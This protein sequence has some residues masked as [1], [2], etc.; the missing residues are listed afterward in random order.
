MTSSR[1][2]MRATFFARHPIRL[3]LSAALL[4]AAASPLYADSVQRVDTL[5]VTAAGFE[6]KLTD[7]PASISVITREDL[8]K[9]PYMTLLDAV[10]DLEGVDVGETRDKTG[11]GSI[12]M[13]GMGAD[14]TLILINGRRQNNNGDIYPNS[15][16]GNQFNHI[17]PLDAIERIEVI[18]GPAATLYGADAMGGVINIITRRDME[19]WSGSLTFGR[20]YQSNKDLGDDVTTDVYLTG[21]LIPGI[22]GMALRGSLYDRMASNPQY[23]PVTDPAGEKHQRTLGFGGGG[24]TV[25]NTNLAG[26]FSLYWTPDERQHITFDYDTSEQTYNNDSSQL[27]TLDSI[28]TVWRAQTINGVSGQVAPRVGYNDDQRFTREQWA[29]THEGRWDFAKT[30]VSLSHISSQNHGRTLPFTIDERQHLQ[31]IYSGTGVYAGL[32]QAERK[33]LAEATFLPRP[34]RTM[35]SREYTLDAKLEKLMGNHQVVAGGQLIR[36]ELEDG[37]FG[38][39]GGGYKSG[40]VQEHHMWALF[41]EDNWMLTPDL[42]LTGGLRYDN[43]D[44]FGGQTSP[45]LYAVYNLSDA[46]TVKGGVSTGYK[47]PKTTDLFPGI[48]G[49]GG[50]GTG[51]WA[52]NPDLKPETSINQEI[53]VYYESVQGHSFNATLFQTEFEDKIS[54]GGDAIPPCEIASPGQKCADVGTGWASLYPTFSQSQNIDRVD[55]QGVELA[56]RLLLPFD[57]TLRANYTYTDS[58]QKTGSNAGRP[59][60]NSAKH[61][62]NATLDWQSTDRLNLFL[63]MEARSDSY[64]GWDTVTDTARYYKD[65]EVFSLGASYRAADNVTINGRINNLFDRDFTSYQTSFTDNGDGTYTPSYTDDYNNK[66]KARNFWVSVNVTF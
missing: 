48:R 3:A 46:W 33:A 34:N 31:E 13:R 62:A 52:G 37:V 24:R 45:R 43:H 49:F 7:A 12:S 18:R 55:L 44:V 26:G 15:F 39:Y 10:R 16:G 21:P 32:S 5:V 63:S 38:M 61:M 28:D 4:S 59:L 22:L 20:T 53:A 36:G 1:A 2:P 8:S 54:G 11:Q 25:A 6:Q 64:R 50:Q 35:E 41:A 66:D 29:I 42:T 30:Q 14:Y 27:G 19:K 9:R 65:Y 23:A 57:L 58:E 56:G 17:P 60:N 40:E 47:T 51:P